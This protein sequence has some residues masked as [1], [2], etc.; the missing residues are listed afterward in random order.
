MPERFGAACRYRRIVL[1]VR[2]A[3]S[4]GRRSRR[5]G[6]LFRRNPRSRQAGAG[7]A[8]HHRPDHSR[9]NSIWLWHHN[10]DR[11]AARSE[12]ID[13]QATSRWRGCSS[14]RWGSAR[15]VPGLIRAGRVQRSQHRVPEGAGRTGEPSRRH[16][17]RRL[18][19]R[20][21][22]FVSI[23]AVPD[24]L[25]TERDAAAEIEEAERS[26]RPARIRTRTDQARALRLGIS[27][28]CR[29]NSAGSDRRPNG[30]RASRRT[31]AS[32]PRSSAK[33]C[34]RWARP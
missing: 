27:P 23:P 15:E 24:A 4:R 31:A 1:R 30:R 20:Q 12:Q 22:S 33:R 7:V 2:L 34:R 14:R 6:H 8:R 28:S 3:P 17:H 32:F 18:R 29:K 9:A 16:A 19:T 13:V 21:V 26:E 5:H 11:P 25:A 10:S